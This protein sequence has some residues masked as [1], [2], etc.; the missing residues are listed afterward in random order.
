MSKRQLLHL[1]KKDKINQNP[2]EVPIKPIKNED[3][4]IEKDVQQLEAQMASSKGSLVVTVQDT[5]FFHQKSYKVTSEN[6]INF[7]AVLGIKTCGRRKCPSKASTME[8]I[9]SIGF[10]STTKNSMIMLQRH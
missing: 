2:S 10:N 7:M 9:W 3:E 6:K 8:S 4:K 5:V 1:L